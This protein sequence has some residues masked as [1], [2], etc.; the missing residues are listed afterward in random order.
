MQGIKTYVGTNYTLHSTVQQSNLEEHEEVWGFYP[1]DKP[2]HTLALKG[3]S[4]AAL[5][6]FFAYRCTLTCSYSVLRL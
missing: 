2:L 6:P 5:A 1:D 4:R 3:D